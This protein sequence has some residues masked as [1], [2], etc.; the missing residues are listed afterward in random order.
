MKIH[1]P[2]LLGVSIPYSQLIVVTVLL[3]SGCASLEPSTDTAQAT[4]VASEQKEESVTGNAD[5]KKAETAQKP[6]LPR[7]D[8][9]PVKPFDKETLYL[10]LAAEFAGYRGQYD[11][12]MSNYVKAT[13]STQDP[14]I[15]ERATRLASYLK[16]D[17]AA[18]QTARVWAQTDPDNLDAHRHAA[19][20]L[21]KAGRLEEAMTHMEAI[22]RL[23]GSANFD[24]FA[25]R[26]ANLDPEGRD[27]LLDAMTRL[28]EDYPGDQQL[29]FSRAVLLEQVGRYEEAVQVAD[30]LLAKKQD[31]NFI[32]LKVNGLKQ[33][34][35]ADE[36]VDFL[37]SAVDSMPEN[38]RLR[39]VYARHLFA[40]DRLKDAAAQYEHVLEESPDD[41][42]ILFA[43]ALISMEQQDDHATRKY[44]NRMIQGNR[45]A[46][47][48]HF[49]LGRLA[50]TNGDISS[51]IE[52]Y[53]RAGESYGYLP[54]QSRVA[55]LL[56][57]QGQ[58]SEARSYLESRRA[59]QPDRHD[60]LIQIEAQLLSEQGLEPQTFDV[61]DK[62]IAVEPGN[63]NLLYVR[64]MMAQ[65]FGHLDIL[66]RDLRRIIELDPDHADALN[67]LGYTL[68]DQTDRHEEAL[69]LIERAI[70]IRPNEAAFIDS[71]GWVQYKLRNYEQ[72]AAHLRRALDM[73][74]NDEV[75]AHLG[76]V[77][78]VMGKKSEANE[79]WEK[80]LERT[81]DSQI[82]KDVIDRL[83]DS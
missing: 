51:A 64:A 67:A 2:N 25:Y 79:V 19:D 73:L 21:M 32:I 48:A 80:A 4:Q 83:R 37:A 49:Y 57:E 20:Q 78:W 17:D 54:A 61:L 35:R 74:P 39:L 55:G 60:D 34:N 36:A 52:K 77:L 63:T 81:P 6:E 47:E 12:A 15:A 31:V 14:G 82:L 9:Y 13:Q 41:G 3:I 59:E 72:A 76:E 26:A 42:D 50:E 46:G 11:V 66:E 7:P 65:K 68:T 56:L 75:A 53:K 71:L 22:K 45:R 10:L 29:M 30:E 24:V 33:L 8:E 23:G 62:A 43:L 28:L 1:K 5:S 58:V 70:E 69:A 18:R 16:R 44:L 27:A 38:R 40:A